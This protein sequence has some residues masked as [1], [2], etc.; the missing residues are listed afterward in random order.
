MHATAKISLAAETKKIRNAGHTLVFGR[1]GIFAGWPFNSGFHQYGNGNEITVAYSTTR[2]TLKKLPDGGFSY[3]QSPSDYSGVSRSFDGGRQWKEDPPYAFHKTRTARCV[4]PDEGRGFNSWVT[5]PREVRTQPIDPFNPSHSLYCGADY[6]YTTRD[7]GRTW[8]GPSFLP[9]DGQQPGFCNRPVYFVRPD[10]VL[11]TFPTVPR[12]KGDEG[13]IMT[14]ASY[15]GGVTWAFLSILAQNDDYMCIMPTVV[16]T[17]AGRLLA[18]VRV[19]QV[20]GSWTELHDSADGGQTWQRIGRLNDHGMPTQLI[21]LKDQRIAAIYGYRLPPFGI[22]ARVSEDHEGRAWGPELILRDDAA[23]S[24]LGY[25]R[26]G[27]T[28][29]GAVVVCYYFHEKKYPKPQDCD[30][31]HWGTRSIWATRFRP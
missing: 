12:R 27:V 28:A 23:S 31:Y 9:R 11:L 1:K 14:Y 24:D 3:Q 5:T 20:G 7:R 21:T 29:D 13:R 2:C 6:I 10:G 16:G 4:P 15:D 18:A 26:G 30:Q 8:S 19:D 22:R 25:P 17:P